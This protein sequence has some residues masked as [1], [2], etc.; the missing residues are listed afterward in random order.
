LA[1]LPATVTPILSELKEIVDHMKERS[2]QIFKFF[3]DY[4]KSAEYLSKEVTS[5]FSFE[6]LDKIDEC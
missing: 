6:Y 4:K 1:T 3:K 2:N 5:P